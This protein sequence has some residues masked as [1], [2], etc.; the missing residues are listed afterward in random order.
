MNDICQP[1]VRDSESMRTMAIV[2]YV[3][4]LAGLFTGLAA[5]GAVI[6]A[7][8]QREDAR[9]TVWESHYDAIIIT[10]WVG[11]VG[12]IAGGILMIVLVGFLVWFA[13]AIWF[14]YRA[15]RGL[16]HAIDCKPY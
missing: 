8:L 1:R 2:A 15:I 13:V 12:L 6:I 9:C 3:C 4:L 16:V 11:L 5:I 10:F 7:Y 14:L